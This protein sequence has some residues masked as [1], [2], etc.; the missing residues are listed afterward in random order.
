MTICSLV[1]QA[2]PQNLTTVNA[3]L[4]TMEGVEVH[5]QDERGKIV[6]TIDHPSR[7]YCSNAMTTMTQM[8]GVMSASLVY[9]YQED[10]E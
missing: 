3:S 5:A 9:E 6:V 8:D 2:R 4:K 7:E 1:I 10:L